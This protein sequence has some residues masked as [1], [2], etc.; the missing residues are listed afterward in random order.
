MTDTPQLKNPL[1]RLVMADGSVHEVQTANPDLLAWDFTYTKHKW[2]NQMEAP[3]LWFTFITWKAAVRLALI[4]PATKWDD[5]KASALEC[6]A[7]DTGPTK[8]DRVLDALRPLLEAA[9]DDTGLDAGD[10]SAVAE[11][12]AA[13]ANEPDHPGRPAEPEPVPPTSPGHEPTY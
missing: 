7:V 5:F 11:A 2:P 3:I 6:S 4:D 12:V 13:V 10:T 8:L 9:E 1:I